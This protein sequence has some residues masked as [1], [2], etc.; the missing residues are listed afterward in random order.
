MM[1]RIIVLCWVL[2]CSTLVEAAFK[3]GKHYERVAT[4]ITQKAVVREI[5]AAHKDAVVV[6]EFFSYGCHWCYK[7]DPT[8]EALRKKL[9]QSVVFER[10]P[11]EF[12]PSWQP[13]TKAY[14][15]QLHL[16]AESKIHVPLFSA[17]QTGTLNDASEKALRQFFVARGISSEDFNKTYNSPEVAQ[18]QKWALSLSKAMQIMSVPSI[19]VLGPKG[20]YISTMSMAG[21]EV[22]L[23]KVVQELVHRV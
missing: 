22:Q 23:M 1:K 15:T 4:A 7:L 12:H 17:I 8:V 19:V 2:L 14:Y 13:F 11:V 18:K 6:L 20:A 3:E 5:M 16:R 10:I 9:P 21:D